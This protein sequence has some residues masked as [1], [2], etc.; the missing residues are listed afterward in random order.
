M[1][2]A[3]AARGRALL[4]TH[5]LPDPQGVGLARRGWRWVCELALQHDLEVLLVTRH[6]GQPIPPTPL[7]GRL[8]TIPLM[9]TPVAPRPIARTSSSA[10]RTALP[11]SA[12]SIA[13]CLPSV[14]ATPIK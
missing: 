13:S 14:S 11:A 9:G 12:K 4:L 10:K 2:D 6:E 1:N 3:P 5:V 8:R 7:P